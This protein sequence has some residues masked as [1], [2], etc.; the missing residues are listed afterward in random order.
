MV[1]HGTSDALALEL[2]S[3]AEMDGRL[4]HD[5]ATGSLPTAING[6]TTMAPNLALSKHDLIQ[7][8]IST[9]MC[10][11]GVLFFKHLRNNLKRTD[12]PKVLRIN[13]LSI[14]GLP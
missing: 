7:S 2:D 11:I 13:F 9:A 12:Q 5:A 10:E 1:L 14:Y 3:K 6:W 8:M 4:S